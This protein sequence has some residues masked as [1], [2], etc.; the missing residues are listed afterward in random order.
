[1]G[2]VSPRITAYGCRSPESRRCG[3][4]DGA[5]VAALHPDPAGVTATLFEGGRDY[6]GPPTSALALETYQSFVDR[7]WKPMSIKDIRK[8][9][10]IIARPLNPELSSSHV[11]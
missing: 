8:S 1:M 3:Y 7:G 11:V 4:W 5:F 9:S 2:N 6:V 10:G